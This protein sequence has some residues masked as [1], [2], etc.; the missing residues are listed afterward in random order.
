MYIIVRLSDDASTYPFKIDGDIYAD[1]AIWHL[2]LRV[3]AS[4]TPMFP[5]QKVAK[6]NWL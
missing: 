3:S 5:S 1:G 6:T 4:N 2:S